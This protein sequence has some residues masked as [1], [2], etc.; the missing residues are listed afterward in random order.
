MDM[1]MDSMK[2]VCKSHIENFGIEESTC[3]NFMNFYESASV[4]GVT[5]LE[6][7]IL[8]TVF[9]NAVADYRL[10]EAKKAKESREDTLRKMTSHCVTFMDDDCLTKPK[11]EDFI[12]YYERK[13]KCAVRPKTKKMLTTVFTVVDTVVHPLDT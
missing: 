1:I 3:E 12:S 11:A 7:D 4:M 10:E 2:D 6:K 8:P 9:M 13:E 5:P